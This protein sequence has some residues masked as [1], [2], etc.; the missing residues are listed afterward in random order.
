MLELPQ[1]GAHRPRVAAVAAAALRRVPGL[2]PGWTCR[3][4][5]DDSV[6]AAIVRRPCSAMPIRRNC[7]VQFAGCSAS[8]SPLPIHCCDGFQ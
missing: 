3:F 1:G 2:Y 4:Y 6:S 5:I 7:P 8:I